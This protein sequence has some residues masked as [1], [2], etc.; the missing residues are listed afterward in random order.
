MKLQ[1]CLNL[2]QG[3]MQLNHLIPFLTQWISTLN[4]LSDYGCWVMYL[5]VCF[6]VLSRWNGVNR[7]TEAIVMWKAADGDLDR[8]RKVREIISNFGA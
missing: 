5:F 2:S 4:Y 1:I 8:D 7:V 3:N 6:D